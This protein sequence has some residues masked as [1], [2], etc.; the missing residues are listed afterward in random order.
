MYEDIMGIYIYLMYIYIYIRNNGIKATKRCKHRLRLQREISRVAKKKFR[1]KT[2]HPK[3]KQCFFCLSVINHNFPLQSSNQLRWSGGLTGDYHRWSQGSLFKPLPSFCGSRKRS[4][5]LRPMRLGI[6]GMTWWTC[7]LE[8]NRV[9][10][11]LYVFLCMP[12]MHTYNVHVYLYNSVYIEAS[13][14]PLNY[15]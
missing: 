3:K 6:M 15:V 2:T 7:R 8:R 5:P 10:M 11:I 12:Y 13:P 9:S 4:K 1:C 14:S